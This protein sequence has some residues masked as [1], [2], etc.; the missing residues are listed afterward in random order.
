MFFQL[1]QPKIEDKLKNN[2]IIFLGNNW[3]T[4]EQFIE[5]KYSFKLK[6]VTNDILKGKLPEKMDSN[7]KENIIQIVY[8]YLN[9][10]QLNNWM[11]EIDN[12]YNIMN[13]KDK[14][15]EEYENN[16]HCISQR[17]IDNIKSM[18]FVK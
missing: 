1:T 17:I 5:N 7:I 9:T 18:M 3:N 14:E 11:T 8:Y 6:K 16:M 15:S 4:I 12:L 13:I 2:Q 10:I